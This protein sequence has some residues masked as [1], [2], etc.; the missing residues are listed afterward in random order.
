MPGTGFCFVV[1][2]ANSFGEISDAFVSAGSLTATFG[3]GVSLSA[4]SVKM[5]SAAVMQQVLIMII[6]VF[7]K[8]LCIV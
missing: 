6:E 5:V 4:V 1:F 3:A 7:C 8:S 2:I